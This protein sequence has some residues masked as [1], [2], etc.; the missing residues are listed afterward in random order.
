M[1]GFFC[2]QQLFKAEAHNSHVNCKEFLWQMWLNVSYCQQ[3][4]C[5]A[6]VFVCEKPTIRIA[7]QPDVAFLFIFIRS[8]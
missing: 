1:Q 5:S 2:T 6:V 7:L 8:L 4:A 3:I